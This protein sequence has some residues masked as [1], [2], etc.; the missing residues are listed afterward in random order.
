[1]RCSLT[2]LLAVLLPTSVYCVRESYA[3]GSTPVLQCG[4][5]ELAVVMECFQCTPFQ[6]RSWLPCQPTGFI[7]EVI[8]HQSNTVDHRS[9]H[10]RHSEEWFFWR[11]EGGVMVLTLVFVLLVLRRQR[12]LDRLAAEKVQRQV[13][14]V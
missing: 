14:S 10:S 2:V 12:T 5:K 6:M 13:Q 4:Q 3:G 9:C 7:E 8:C 1:M 11:F